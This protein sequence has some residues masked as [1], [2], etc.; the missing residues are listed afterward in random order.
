M[1]ISKFLKKIGIDV[2]ISITKGVKIV[3]NNKEEI[4]LNGKK[5]DPKSKEY[6]Q[7]KKSIDRSMGVLNDGLETLGDGLAQMGENLRNMFK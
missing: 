5:L 2:D 1:N 6:K 3:V 4:W 7:A